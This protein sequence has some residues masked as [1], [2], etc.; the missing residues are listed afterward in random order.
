MTRSGFWLSVFLFLTLASF[1]LQVGIDPSTDNL[2]TASVVVAS[3]LGILAYMFWTPALQTHPLSTFA[4]FGFCVTTQFGALV[5]QSLSFKPVM[6]DLWQ[7][8]ETFLL[9]A[10]FQAIAIISHAFYRLFSQSAPREQPSLLRNILAATDLYTTPSAASLWL[11]GLF[12]LLNLLIVQAGLMVIS[13]IAQ[14]FSL[15]AWAPFLIPMFLEQQGSQYCAARRNYFFLAFY[16]VAIVIVGVAANTRGMM[17]SGIMTIALF[18][19]LSALRSDK[20]ISRWY[21]PSILIGGILLALTAI[22]ISDFATAMVLARDSRTKA[23]KLETI[24]NTIYYFRNPQLL[25]ARRERDKLEAKRGN[26]DEIYLENPLVARL[27]ETKFHDNAFYYSARIS[28]K[29]AEE[30]LETTG[31]F[32]WAALPDPM[33][34]SLKI[35]VDKEKLR[36]SMGDYL[37]HL[38]VGGPLGGYRTGSALAQGFVIFGDIFPVIYFFLCPVLFYF[39]DLLS[40]RAG[41]GQV[42]ISA[43][44]MLG[45]WRLFQYGI[46]AESLHHIFIGIVRGVPQNILTYLMLTVVASKIV[47]FY[48]QKPASLV[49]APSLRQ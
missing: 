10:M 39:L 49:N 23:S 4:I 12:G 2:A 26:Y 25:Q 21:A 24:E 29:G 19:L 44:G 35:D 41:N 3:T 31:E 47:Q 30:L 38:S 17:L 40:F 28:E 6:L 43:L 37:V 48:T 14:A 18:G 45:V 33:L 7:P 16:T 5:A 9:L 34:K 22:P 8:F 11:V 46:S 13:Q 32:F 20:P 1:G 27:V 42:L 15:L 36:F